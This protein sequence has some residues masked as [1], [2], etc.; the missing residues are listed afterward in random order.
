MYISL[1]AINAAAK[2]V[3]YTVHRTDFIQQ[4]N[5]NYSQTAYYANSNLHHKE[6]D[7]DQTCSCDSLCGSGM[8]LGTGGR[9]VGDLGG[10]WVGEALE[11]WGEGGVWVWRG[12][13]CWWWPGGLGPGA[14]PYMSGRERSSGQARWEAGEPRWE[15]TA[16]GK[17]AR[18]GGNT[19]RQLHNKYM[20]GELTWDVHGVYTKLP[21]AASDRWI[22]IIIRTHSSWNCQIIAFHADRQKLIHRSN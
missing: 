2:V 3:C 6:T 4:H 16:A 18:T 13:L 21:L 9:E 8:G 11:E 19:S 7:K 22:F 12:G 20:Q 5:W 15:E 17:G 1:K 10:V 14:P